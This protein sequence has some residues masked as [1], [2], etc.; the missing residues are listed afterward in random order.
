[1]KKITLVEAFSA[2]RRWAELS[3]EEQIDLINPGTESYTAEVI[4]TN[5]DRII[6]INFMLNNRFIIEDYIIS[7]D[8]CGIWELSVANRSWFTCVEAMSEM[9]AVK[10]I[11]DASHFKRYP[12]IDAKLWRN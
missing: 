1:M 2:M 10:Y 11:K 4:S 12:C 7:D 8:S 6:T 3:D 9:D 5:P